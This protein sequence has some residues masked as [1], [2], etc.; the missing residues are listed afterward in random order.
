M[1]RVRACRLG[2]GAGWLAAVRAYGE[3][4]NLRLV[5]RLVAATALAREESRGAH[6]RRDHPAPGPLAAPPDCVTAGRARRRRTRHAPK[7][8]MTA[9]P[10]LLVEP[11]IRAALAEDLGRAGDLTTEPRSRPAPAPRRGFA[12]AAP[13]ASPGS[14]PRSLAF[15]LLDPRLAIEVGVPDGDAM[16]RRATP[17]PPSTATRAPSSPPSA[18][19]STCSAGS[20][21]SPPPP[22]RPWP[23][24]AGTKARSR[25]HPQD[26]AGPARPGEV[27]RPLG[28]GMNHRFGLDDGVLIKDNHIVAA[29]GVLAAV[30]RARAG[31]GHMVK[32]EVEVDTLDQLA[33]RR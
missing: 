12:P 7:A 6:F 15:R 19:P 29:G 9:R 2:T 33:A 13:A 8:A 27:R 17:S 16:P 14:T 11:L 18:P 32:L 23:A 24:V 28:G 26:H 4:R 31:I 25:L 5:A 22:A 30:D 20:A 10:P 3:L 21:A 1:S